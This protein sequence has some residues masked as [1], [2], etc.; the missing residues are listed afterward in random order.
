MPTSINQQPDVEVLGQLLSVQ[1][2]LDV[3]P[4][5]EGLFEFLC[6]ALGDV[7]GITTV[8]ACTENFSYPQDNSFHTVCTFCAD[9]WPY[10]LDTL[11]PACK[12]SELPDVNCIGMRTAKAH[13]GFMQLKIC[14]ASKYAPYEPFVINLANYMAVILENR[15]RTVELSSAKETAESAN[16][17]KSEFL[18]RMSHELRTPLNGILGYSQILR[19]DQS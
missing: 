3:M 2:T 17:A 18:A 12:L 11:Q 15:R 10:L 1:S 16:N 8:H 7:P 4:T 13:Y 9:S 6:H 14:D 5:V 19:R